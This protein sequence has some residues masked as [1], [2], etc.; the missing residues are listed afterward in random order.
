MGLI[1]EDNVEYSPW[2]DITVL[3]DYT[4]GDEN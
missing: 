4:R 2:D 3:L 1:K